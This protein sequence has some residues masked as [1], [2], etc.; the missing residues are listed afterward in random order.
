[1]DGHLSMRL[2]PDNSETSAVYNEAR[3]LAGVSLWS[4]ASFA[5]TELRIRQIHQFMCN[6]FQGAAQRERQDLKLR[7]EIRASIPLA[8]L[9]STIEEHK[10]T[11][12]L[13]EYGV[14]QTSLEQVFNMIARDQQHCQYDQSKGPRRT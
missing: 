6:S 14:S 12:C 1:M 11:L 8:D 13:S 4:L 7:Y 3:S 2:A 9:F 10:E 5:A